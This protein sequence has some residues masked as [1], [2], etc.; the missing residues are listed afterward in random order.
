[1]FEQTFQR[2]QG[3]LTNLSDLPLEIDILREEKK[4]ELLFLILRQLE[5]ALEELRRAQLPPGQLAERY[6]E[7]LQDIWRSVT[8]DFFG[9][10]YT[11][12][13]D[14]LE[15]P[16]VNTLLQEAETVQQ[17]ILAPIPQVPMLL[18]HLLYQEPMIVDG[19]SYVASTP[20]AL[21]RSQALLENLLL[22]LANGIIQ[23]ML[24]R[25]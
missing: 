23:P 12:E 4:R 1:M 14:N 13:V 9:R 7:V 20:E 16:V 5:T 3:S 2:L 8:T 17:S 6:P 22:Q 15:Q 11:L 21:N 24:N 18:G 25:F 19:S 10:Y